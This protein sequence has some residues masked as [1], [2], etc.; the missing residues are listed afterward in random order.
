MDTLVAGPFI[1]HKTKQDP[2]L[3]ERVRAERQ[4][5]AD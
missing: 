1:L 4:F 2:A 5:E 3:I